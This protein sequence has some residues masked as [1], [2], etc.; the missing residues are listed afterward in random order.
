MRLPFSIKWIYLI[1]RGNFD[2]K[3]KFSNKNYIVS[4][5]RNFQKKS[6]G[7]FTYDNWNFKPQIS[8][9][10]QF[11]RASDGGMAHVLGVNKLNFCCGY[12]SWEETIWGNTVFRILDL[13]NLIIILTRP[14]PPKLELWVFRISL[15]DSNQEN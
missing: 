2:H 14:E 5:W 3:Y 11:D 4:T 15:E 10:F 13:K 6:C 7:I 12:S 9:I 1:E 8:S